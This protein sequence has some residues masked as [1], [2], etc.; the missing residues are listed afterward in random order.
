MNRYRKKVVEIHNRH[1]EKVQIHCDEYHAHSVLMNCLAGPTESVEIC[2]LMAYV[3]ILEGRLSKIEHL[4]NMGR[5][6]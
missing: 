3:L 6:T 5:I 2:Y 4:A 1:A